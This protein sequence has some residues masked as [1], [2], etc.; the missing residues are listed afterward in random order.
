VI[1]DK[2]APS[3][4]VPSIVQN[5]DGG[6]KDSEASASHVTVKGSEQAIPST[7][8]SNS[9]PSKAVSFRVFQVSLRQVY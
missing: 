3:A 7:T 2:E 1:T 8:G 9:E 6:V 4:I 5:E